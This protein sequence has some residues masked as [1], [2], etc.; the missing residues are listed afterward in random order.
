MKKTLNQ[1]LEIAKAGNWEKAW[2]VAQE[3]EGL[4]PEVTKSQW[5]EFAKKAIERREMWEKNYK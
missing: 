1:A 2:Q 4:L 5:I 3:D